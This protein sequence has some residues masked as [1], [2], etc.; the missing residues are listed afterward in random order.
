M[1]E[2]D[3]SVDKQGSETWRFLPVC[4]PMIETAKHEQKQ[5]AI[6]AKD[7][8]VPIFQTGINR[9]T[10]EADSGKHVGM[11]FVKARPKERTGNRT[12][13]LLGSTFLPFLPKHDSCERRPSK[14][15]DKKISLQGLR[16]TV[17]PTYG[18]AS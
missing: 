11:G 9:R 3:S 16:Q 17:F 15:W 7:F 2:R 1:T 8:E 12:P 6:W 13:E 14:G 18:N 4:P 5:Q 10:V